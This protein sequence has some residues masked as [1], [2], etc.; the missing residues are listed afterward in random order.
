M[1]SSSI[2]ALNSNVIDNVVAQIRKYTT[3]QPQLGIVCGS[4]MGDLID[5]IENQTVV[6]YSSVPAFLQTTVSGHAGNFVFGKVGSVQVVVMQGRLHQYEGFS[7]AQMHIPIR[8][9]K[10]LGVSIVLLTNAAG[11]LSDKLQVGDFVVLKD[12]ISPSGMCT[13]NVLVGPNDERFG[14]RFPATLDAYDESLR[15][16][17]LLVAEKLSMR[18]HV[19]EGV[20]FH[21]MGPTYATNAEC[22]VM[23]MMGADVVGMS[24]VPEVFVARHCGLR[25]VAVSLITDICNPNC[26][27]LKPLTHEEVLEAA[28]KNTLKLKKLIQEF[29]REL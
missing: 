14:P 13:G 12:H 23:C 25:V 27:G 11:G 15:K 5:F 21:V 22:K 26:V 9:L 8:V 20:Y 18:N 16:K 28:K 3:M 29:I 1:S 19:H 17:M 7:I 4:G 2:T 10:L 24:T 6:P